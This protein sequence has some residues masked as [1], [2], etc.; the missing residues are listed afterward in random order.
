VA[1]NDGLILLGI[2]AAALYFLTRNKSGPAPVAALPPA[3]Q[4]IQPQQPGQ[5][6]QGQQPNGI[7]PGVPYSHPQ[8]ANGQVVIEPIPA[9]GMDGMSI[10]DLANSEPIYGG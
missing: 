3:A 9:G 7:P 6:P 10:E 5:Q 2:G 4:A 8:P 1:N